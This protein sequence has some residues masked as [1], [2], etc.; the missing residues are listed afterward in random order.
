[1]ENKN[2]ILKNRNKYVLSWILLSFCFAFTVKKQN[3]P[4]KEKEIIV[5]SENSKLDW[6]FF[7]GNP[8]KSSHEAI[9]SITIYSKYEDAPNLTINIRACF[10]K[11]ESWKKDK[12]PSDYLLNHEQKHF[13]ITEIYARKL[14]K[15]LTETTFNSEAIAKREIPK[16][17]RDNNK[18]LNV[19]QDLYD[20]ETNHSINKENQS[21]WDK[22]IEEELKAAAN[23]IN[24]IIVIKK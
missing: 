23:Y 5:W 21:L 2:Q 20:K 18:A 19:Y 1:M 15:I 24:N 16:I 7:K 13:D 10:I 6:D 14:R 4:Y 9:S 11:K 22:R 8:S 3:V 17:I 12:L